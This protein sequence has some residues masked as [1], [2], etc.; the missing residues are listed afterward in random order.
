MLVYVAQYRVHF[1]SYNT[2]LISCLNKTHSDTNTHTYIHTNS[3]TNT[4]KPH[5]H[6]HSNRKKKHTDIHAYTHTYLERQTQ[7]LIM[8]G[9]LF[10]FKQN[11]HRHTHT[12]TPEVSWSWVWDLR[13]G[14]RWCTI[15]ASLL[16]QVQPTGGPSPIT[17][18]RTHTCRQTER[19]GTVGSHYILFR[20]SNT[21]WSNKLLPPALW[22]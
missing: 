12:H 6:M 4:P 2:Y 9:F 16:P 11:T 13:P 15:P 5:T 19:N 7:T 3:H 10:A 1:S 18:E 8:S 17:G 21:I 14:P 22:W 20:L